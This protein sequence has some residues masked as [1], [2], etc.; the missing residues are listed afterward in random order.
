MLASNTFA[1]TQAS[2]QA[3]DAPASPD[4]RPESAKPETAPAHPA[5]ADRPDES[6]PRP[7][8]AEAI[9]PA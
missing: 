1:K 6:A 8:D 4:N 7:P 9:S 2:R 5:T 3:A